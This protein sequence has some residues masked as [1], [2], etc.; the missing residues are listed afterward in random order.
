MQTYHK[1]VPWRKSLEC[2]C[3]EKQPEAAVLWEGFRKTPGSILPKGKQTRNQ[4][5][6]LV[7]QTV[8]STMR[9]LSATGELFNLFGLGLN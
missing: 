5:Y 1:C 2:S 3:S 4:Q 9:Y 6:N 8:G 7:V